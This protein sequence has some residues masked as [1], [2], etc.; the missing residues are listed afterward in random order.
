MNELIRKLRGL[1]LVENIRHNP[2]EVPDEGGVNV[3][4]A[5]VTFNLGRR[6]GIRKIASVCSALELRVE[7]L[8]RG[9]RKAL[10]IRG[11][12]WGVIFQPLGIAKSDKPNF[13]IYAVD[14]GPDL[15]GQLAHEARSL[16][17]RFFEALTSRN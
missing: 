16:I 14:N 8:S 12:K 10:H 15:H 2:F 4:S 13:K 9:K 3:E 11:N 1:P 7:T 6:V 17:M 5:N